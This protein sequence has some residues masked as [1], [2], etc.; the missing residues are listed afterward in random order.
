M[1]KEEITEISDIPNKS[2]DLENENLYAINIKFSFSTKRK[3][4]MMRYIKILLKINAIK[5][6]TM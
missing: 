4:C 5:N 2:S 1:I 6:E 3:F